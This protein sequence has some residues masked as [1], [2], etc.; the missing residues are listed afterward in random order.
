MYYHYPYDEP[1][2]IRTVPLN[3]SDFDG[4]E[5]VQ[6]LIAESQYGFLMELIEEDCQTPLGQ[7]NIAEA[8]K[9]VKRLLAQY[10]NLINK[11]K[12]RIDNV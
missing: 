4:K 11:E 2:K 6:E 7:E 10:P 3:A 12:T 9:L 8:R 5:F 1:Q